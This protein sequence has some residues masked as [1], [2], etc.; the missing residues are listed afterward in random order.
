MSAT[1]FEQLWP[2]TDG[3][4]V[5]KTR[6]TLLVG[7]DTVELDRFEG[8]LKGLLLVEVEFASLE[9]ARRFTPPDWFGQEVTE[10]KRYKNKHLSAYGIPG[11]SSA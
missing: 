1:Q 5:S 10:D 4:R 9:E 3:R 11:S 8:A 6:Y 2:H 7:E